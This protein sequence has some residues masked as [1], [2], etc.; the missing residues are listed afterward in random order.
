MK[1]IK[2]KTLS[3]PFY[4]FIVNGLTLCFGFIFFIVISLSALE[5]TSVIQAKKNLRTFAYSLA[6][7][8]QNKNNLLLYEPENHEELKEEGYRTIDRFVKYT[9]SHDPA[10]RV[11]IVDENGTVVADSDMD[12]NMVGNHIDREEIKEAL[13]GREGSSIRRSSIYDQN[14]IYYAIPFNYLGKNLALRLSIP[15]QENAFFSSSIRSD[16]I[17]SALIVLSFVLVISFL[18][19][20]KVL[21]PLNELEETARHYQEGDF[22][23][24]PNISSPVEFVELA[25]TFTSMSQTIRKN[26]Q[27]IS[28][29]RDELQTVF[30]GITEAIV[31]FNVDLQILQLNDVAMSFFLVGDVKNLKEKDALV[32]VVKNTEII[33][34]VK[35]LIC[36]EANKTEIETKLVASEEKTVAAEH[37]PRS[38]LVRCVKINDSINTDE[39]YLLVVTDISR[40]KRLERVRKDFVANV[41]HELKT[42]ITAIKGFIETLQDG[43]VEEPETARHFLGIMEQQ[44]LRL[45]NIIEDLLTLSK[46]EQNEIAIETEQ[47]A[48]QTLVADVFNT[49]YHVAASKNISLSQVFLPD[50]TSIDVFVNPGLFSQAIS[51]LV[52][53]AIKYCPEHSQVKL[54]ASLETKKPDGSPRRNPVV[55]IF[56]EDNGPGIPENARSRIFERFY[57]F[58]SGRSREDGGTGLGLSIVR[59]IIEL[60]GGTVRAVSRPDGQEG[61]CFEIMLPVRKQKRKV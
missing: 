28:K 25:K 35:Q 15:V 46:L 22:E 44:S 48:L 13:S 7:I 54:T 11:T 61:A 32:A 31:V 36:G 29:Q 59:H 52:D 26:I 42:P 1:K 17:I 37:A 19:A 60:H 56:V 20:G 2:K 34:F 41:S 9:A 39:R 21:N 27:D 50:E 18:I 14:L 3:T 12:L 47:V 4:L 45:I 5:R 16:S 24:S 38:V 33:N 55:H 40:L 8:M 58:D 53:N 30:S 43:A 49:Y 6:N 51:N 23:Y 10:F 57:R